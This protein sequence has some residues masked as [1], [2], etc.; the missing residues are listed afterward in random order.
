MEKKAFDLTPVAIAGLELAQAA[1]DGKVN[2]TAFRE[3]WSLEADQDRLLWRMLHEV[4]HFLIDD[5]IRAKDPDYERYQRNL[6]SELM[7]DVR[8]K[9]E[10]VRG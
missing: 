7:H 2:L 10:I 8:V 9:Y 4:E 6:I 3:R 5:A 1:L